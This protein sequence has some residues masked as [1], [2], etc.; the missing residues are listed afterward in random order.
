MGFNDLVAGGQLPIAEIVVPVI[1]D[2]S[3]TVL[4]NDQI[5]HAHA[6]ADA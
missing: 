3:E 6:A 1:E 5:E 2:I 4:Y